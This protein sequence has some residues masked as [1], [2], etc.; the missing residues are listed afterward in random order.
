MI[1]KLVL[2][3][4]KSSSIPVIVKNTGPE[5]YREY[6]IDANGKLTEGETRLSVDDIK[7]VGTNV[8]KSAYANDTSLTGTFSM[9]SSLTTLT[10]G[11][12]CSY[13]C[14]GCTNLT[15]ADFGLLATVSGSNA[16]YY[17]FQGCSKLTSID[18]SS[19]TTIT[20]SY[21]LASMFNGCSRFTTLDL[22][23]LTT[24]SGSNAMR[25]ICNN[26]SSLTNLNLSSL[27]TVTGDY[28]LYYAFRNCTGLTNIDLSSLTTLEGQYSM[29]YAFSGC[30]YVTSIDLSSLEVLNGYYSM[31]NCFNGCSRLTSVDLSSV[32]KLAA[33]DGMSYCFQNC[34]SLTHIEF[35]SLTVIDAQGMFYQGFTG[36]SSL[37]SAD[38]SKLVTMNNTGCM[39]S[40]FVSCR[41]LTDI[42]FSSLKYMDYQTFYMCFQNCNALQELKFPA[43]REDSFGSSGY[44]FYNTLQ[45]VT[46][47]TIYFPKNLDPQTGSTKI[48]S[49]S[50]YPNFGGTNTVLSFSL[51]S[52]FILTGANSTEYE[53][54]PKYDTQTALA[55]RVKDTGTLVDPIIDWTPFYTSGTAD[56]QVN[57]T[58]YSDSTCTTVVTTISTIV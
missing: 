9:L 7:D 41:L 29:Q 55:W 51:P 28:S 18:L 50:T 30:S 39:Y 58:L 11:N 48:S 19:L 3:T 56:P 23:S 2:G 53:R 47:C 57:D 40:G 15:G 17:C 16:L 43:L 46:G 14:S 44:H 13:M 27:T 35:P 32:R 20:G 33:R 49:E 45:G 31:Q 10:G 52:T 21:A 6:L 8:L 12:A 25:E 34:T 54:N 22:S 36:C 4:T 5:N 38:F 1:G 26:V 42:D 37:A 24:V